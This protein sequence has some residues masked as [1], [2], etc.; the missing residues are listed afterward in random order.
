MPW[1]EYESEEKL[2]ISKVQ[3][4]LLSLAIIISPCPVCA[5]DRGDYG[6]GLVFHDGILKDISPSTPHSSIHTDSDYSIIQHDDAWESS[7]RELSRTPSSTGSNLTSLT[8]K[9]IIY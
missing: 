8:D 9:S 5:Y 1:I 2:E 4:I 3:E 7:A 6:E